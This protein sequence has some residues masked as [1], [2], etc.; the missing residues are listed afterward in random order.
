MR[1][2]G[3]I[4][5]W[6]DEQGFGFIAQNGDGKRL[7]LHIRSFSRQGR[8]P[9]LNEI[10]TYEIVSG[11]KGLRAEAVR[12]IDERS[13][14]TPVRAK[15]AWQLC[16]VALFVLL[17]VGAALAGYVSWKVPAF[18]LTASLTAFFY[19]WID[20]S[21]ARHGKWRISE[22]TLHAIGLIGGWPG[23]LLAQRLLGHKSSKSSFRFVFWVTVVL[24]C[25]L[26]AWLY[27]P[28]GRNMLLRIAQ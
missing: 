14:S 17:I 18:Y 20:K 28:Y 25:S 21:A 26:V 6:R 3:K 15:S 11:P 8:R 4:A 22:R 23:G 5:E 16:L 24:H 10:V 12:F 19:Y 7:F 13:A 27:S 2:Q 9:R 1:Y